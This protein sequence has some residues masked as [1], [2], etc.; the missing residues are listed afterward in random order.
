MHHRHLVPLSLGDLGEGETTMSGMN[1]QGEEMGQSLE[2]Q[3]ADAQLQKKRLLHTLG[4]VALLGI[5]LLLFT[6]Y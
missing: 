4:L 3:Q 6:Y 1:H 2:S 5:V